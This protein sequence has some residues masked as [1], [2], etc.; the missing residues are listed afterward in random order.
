MAPLSATRTPTQTFCFPSLDFDL[1][2][3]ELWVSKEGLFP[4]GKTTVVPRR[5]KLKQSDHF[6]T[7]PVGKNVN[8]PG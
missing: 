6:T 3:L 7:K 8:S 1:C 2:C 5:Q 4:L